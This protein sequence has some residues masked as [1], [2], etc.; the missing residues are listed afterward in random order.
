ME[1][2]RAAPALRIMEDLVG[3]HD[4]LNAARCFTAF[5]MGFITMEVDGSFDF[6]GSVEAASVFPYRH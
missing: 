4:A 6:D 5:L 1:A 3:S 2:E